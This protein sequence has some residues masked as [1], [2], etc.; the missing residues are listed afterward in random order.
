ARRLRGFGAY[1]FA[2]WRPAF[3]DNFRWSCVGGR[4]GAFGVFTWRKKLRARRL[5]R[6]VVMVIADGV[7]LVGPVEAFAAGDVSAQGGKVFVV[8]P[9]VLGEKHGGADEKGE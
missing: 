1:D 7:V 9:G 5:C 6:Q 2:F 3:N 8:P 4:G